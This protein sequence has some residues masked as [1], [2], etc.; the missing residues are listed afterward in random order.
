MFQSIIVTFDHAFLNL[1][2]ICLGTISPM[3]QQFK[4]GLRHCVSFTISNPS[5]KR[6]KQIRSPPLDQSQMMESIYSYDPLNFL[7]GLN[8]GLKILL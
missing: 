1:F 5:R 3:Y 4:Y 7:V 2:N 6:K 8:S